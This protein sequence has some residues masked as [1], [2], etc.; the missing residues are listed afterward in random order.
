[1]SERLGGGMLSVEPGEGTVFWPVALVALPW[2]R[3]RSQRPPKKKQ[4]P[5]A[6]DRAGDPGGWGGSR[7]GAAGSPVGDASEQRWPMWA[8]G[9]AFLFLPRHHRG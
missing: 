8:G 7:N 3:R 9:R 5:C 2:L 4:E 6:S 1:V